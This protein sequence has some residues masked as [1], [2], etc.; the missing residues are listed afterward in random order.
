[1]SVNL[2]QFAKRGKF[3]IN[4]LACNDGK[5]ALKETLISNRAIYHKTCYT[6][7][8]DQKLQ[9]L[10]DNE[11]SSSSKTADNDVPPKRCKRS[12][13]TQTTLGDHVGLFCAQKDLPTN[14]CAAGT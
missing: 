2:P 11:S 10:R 5:D 9:R 12:V 13:I 6:R 1:M 7:F 8:N 4:R 3:N 14:L